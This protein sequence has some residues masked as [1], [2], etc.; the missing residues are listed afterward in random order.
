[1]NISISAL[2]KKVKA[3][4]A[5]LANNGCQIEEVEAVRMGSF[6]PSY[7]ELRLTNSAGYWVSL[8]IL[9]NGYGATSKR[10]IS[11]SNGWRDAKSKIKSIV[12]S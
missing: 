2:E 11:T 5:E 1:M 8:N 4:A 9:A 10:H 7:V 3:L 6:G 12:N